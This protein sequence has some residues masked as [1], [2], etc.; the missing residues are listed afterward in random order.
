MEQKSVIVY[1]SVRE[2][3][4]LVTREKEALFTQARELGSSLF[5]SF[6][7]PKFKMTNRGEKFVKISFF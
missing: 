1:A 7:F 4:K 6:I 5:N 2:S 3:S